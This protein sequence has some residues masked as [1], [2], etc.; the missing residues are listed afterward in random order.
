MMPFRWQEAKEV[1]ISLN[2]ELVIKY[3]IFVKVRSLVESKR[4]DYS[5]ILAKM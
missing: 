2:P 4:A 1:F 5:G 3:Y